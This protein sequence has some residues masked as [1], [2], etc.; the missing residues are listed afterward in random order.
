[1]GFVH[2]ASSGVCDGFHISHCMRG[3][4]RFPRLHRGKILLISDRRIGA[5]RRF[6]NGFQSADRPCVSIDRGGVSTFVQ[7]N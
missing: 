5:R 3:A 7:E 6:D 4:Q 1:M 2:P